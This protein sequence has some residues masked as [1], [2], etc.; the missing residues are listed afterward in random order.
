[1]NILIIGGNGFIGSH[2]VEILKNE[3]QVTVFDRSP[4][5]FL[6]ES[7]GVEYVYGNFSDTDLLSLTL[8]NKN[9]VYHLLST[10]VP[11][12]ANQ[13]PI[14]DIQS[15]LIDTVKLLDMVIERN[16]ERFI[17][18][19]SGGT[20]YGNSQYIPIDE[21]HPC[22]PVGSYGIIKN[23]IEQYIQ[24][25]ARRNKFSYLIVRPSNPYGPRQNYKGN[26]GLISKLIYHGI[27]QEKFTIWGDGSAIRD[28]IFIDDLTNFLKIAGLSNE[29]G[30]F[31]IGSGTGKSINEIILLLSD[32]IE[33][34]PPIIYTDKNNSF[35]EKVVLDIKHSN[36]KFDWTP[37]ITLEEGLR[38]HNKWMKLNCKA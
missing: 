14:F 36:E 32:I 29:S 26:Q 38:L 15:N 20:V 35:V 21:K 37:K 34:M 27:S 5:Q 1:L 4:N 25:Y 33:N 8:K 23:T 18:A 12:T 30:I 11:F 7:P 13:D 19:S 22:N 9:V 16:I 24:M 2:L 17:Y 6:A 28:Y 31:N 10:T 3:H